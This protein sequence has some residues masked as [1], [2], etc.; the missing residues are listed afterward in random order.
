MV[1]KHIA[2]WFIFFLES[3]LQQRLTI[4]GARRHVS[5]LLLN[6]RDDVGEC[7][8]T[9]SSRATSPG[10]RRLKDPTDLRLYPTAPGK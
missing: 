2:L 7:G 9:L 5:N 3:L 1:L 6:P 4:V 10:Q 8:N